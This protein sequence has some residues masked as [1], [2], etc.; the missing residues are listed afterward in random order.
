[1]SDYL[2][3]LEERVLIFDGAM[4]TQLMALD[5]SVDDFGGARYHGCNEALVLSRPDLVREIHRAY[6]AAGADVVE[7]DS[8]MG[9]RLKLDEYGL[10]ERTVEINRLAA[11][12]R[13][14]RATR[15]R[16][17]S[18]RDSWPARW[19]RPAC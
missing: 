14:K 1:M 13:A 18:A 6:L 7:T 19:A 4:G 17:A 3:L 9:S 10:G 8:F 16:P 12:W 11:R 2:R 15:L 5:L